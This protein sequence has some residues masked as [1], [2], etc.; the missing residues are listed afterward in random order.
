MSAAPVDVG[1]VVGLRL[2]CGVPLGVGLGPS[3]LGDGASRPVGLGVVGNWLVGLGVGE[4]R[5][6]AMEAGI[7]RTSR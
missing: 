1:E 3:G 6:A 4:E 2:E 7:G 5:W